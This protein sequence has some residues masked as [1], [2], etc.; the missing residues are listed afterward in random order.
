[1]PDLFNRSLL[2]NLLGDERRMFGIHCVS[3][4]PMASIIRALLE[5]LDT[6]QSN[7]LSLP[8]GFSVDIIGITYRPEIRNNI[9]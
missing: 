8:Q 7:Q 5:H 6:H 2:I 1:M 9:C 4:A 3:V